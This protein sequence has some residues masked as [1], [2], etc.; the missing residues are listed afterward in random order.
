LSVGRINT[1]PTLVEPILDDIGMIKEAGST[2]SSLLKNVAV[3]VVLKDAV[4]TSLTRFPRSKISFCGELHRY[5]YSV[6]SFM[7]VHRM[8]STVGS[9]VE[10]LQTSVSPKY[11]SAS[12]SY[13]FPWDVT[14]K[15][16]VTL[17]NLQLGGV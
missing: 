10:V 5:I 1:L 3:R 11:I 13:C 9:A 16:I 6:M 12:R 7:Y 4:Y 2:V 14:V 8:P 15:F 17:L